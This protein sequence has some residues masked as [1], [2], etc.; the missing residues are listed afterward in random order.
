MIARLPSCTAHD[1]DRVLVRQGFVV[2]YQKGSHRYYR[3]PV[4]DKI[5]TTVPMHPGHLSRG[6]LKQIL[7]Q[8][9]FS[10]EQFRKLL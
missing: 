6:L 1:V 2:A 8:V 10:E 4:T 5:V 7:K 9:G 3:S